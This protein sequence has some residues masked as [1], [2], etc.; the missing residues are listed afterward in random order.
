MNKNLPVTKREQFEFFYAG[1]RTKEA[2]ALRYHLKEINSTSEFSSDLDMGI[3]ELCSAAE[4]I[5]SINLSSHAG[6]KFPDTLTTFEELVDIC[7]PTFLSL[8]VHLELGSEDLPCVPNVGT[9][10]RLPRNIGKLKNARY[11]YLNGH[12]IED[13]S[14]LA[15]LEMNFVCLE[16]CRITDVSPLNFKRLGWLNLRGTRIK[17]LSYVAK[18]GNGLGIIPLEGTLVE[19]PKQILD[20]TKLEACST[21]W[22]INCP[23]FAELPDQ[24]GFFIK[25]KDKHNFL[26]TDKNELKNRGQKIPRPTHYMSTDYLDL[27]PDISKP[28][29]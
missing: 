6:G 27:V 21:I 24:E 12:P 5:F 4:C 1:M 3:L 13:L 16:N 29:S 8:L 9:W 22:M 25:E 14:P 17:D 20:L 28:H 26:I 23:A 15:P 10:N 11:V 7:S 19:D 2:D 18:H